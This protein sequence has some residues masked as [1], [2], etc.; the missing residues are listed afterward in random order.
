MLDKKQGFAD[1]FAL[2]SFSLY[3]NRLSLVE[4]VFGFIFMNVT[5]LGREI[6]IPSQVTL[7][8]L[9]NRSFLKICKMG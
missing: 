2:S 8:N 7:I 9:V 4:L 6:N 1:T 3:F 5:E